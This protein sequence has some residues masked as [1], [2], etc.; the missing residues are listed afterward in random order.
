M[1]P[2]P[3]LPETGSSLPHP[4]IMACR[5]LPLLLPALRMEDAIDSPVMMFLVSPGAADCAEGDGSTA[6][7]FPQVPAHAGF[8]LGALISAGTDEASGPGTKSTPGGFITW[9]D[10]VRASGWA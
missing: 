2:E 10:V 5:L 6:P 9:L 3:G 4:L 8:F 7:P 1:A